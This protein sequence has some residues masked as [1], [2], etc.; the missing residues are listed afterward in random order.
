VY[1]GNTET[2]L[3]L[4]LVVTPVLAL[5]EVAKEGVLWVVCPVKAADQE[6]LDDRLAVGPRA[7][8]W[9]CPNLIPT[10]KTAAVVCSLW[11]ACAVLRPQ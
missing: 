11:S 1:E 10:C 8:C 6:L 5:Q 4:W 7:T 2:V 9:Q 3:A